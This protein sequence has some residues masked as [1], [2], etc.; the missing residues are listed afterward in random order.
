MTEHRGIQDNTVPEQ[1][2]SKDTGAPRLVSV[3]VWDLPTRFFHWTL[4]V[5]VAACLFT[6]WAGGA[7]RALHLAAGGVVAA[8]VVFRLVWGL[9]GSEDSRF[10]AFPLSA[11][12]MRAH[13][14]DLRH[15]PAAPHR[16]HNPAGA[17]MVVTLLTLLA[18]IVLSGAVA[19]GGVDKQGPFAL[20]SQATGQSGHAVHALLAWTL[21]ALVVL[22]VA[23]VALG[24]RLERVNLVA[25]MI[26]GRKTLPARRRPTVTA[27]PAAA[28]LSFGA[29]VAAGGVVWLALP[30]V[31]PP[32]PLAAVLRDECGGCH[33]PY[34]P[35]VLTATGWRQM[36]AGLADHFGED[37]ALSPDT[38]RTVE[39]ALTQGGTAETSDR[40]VAHWMRSPDPAAP[41]A[42][43]RSAG[44]QARHRA[45]PE[46]VFT[47]RA[48]SGRGHCSA[49][50]ADAQDGLFAPQAIHLPKESPR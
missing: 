28:A 48:V 13:L 4:L 37:A 8:L 44:W 19:W 6:G 43:T 38:A 15:P 46:T 33:E 10:T 45:L 42:V 5:S 50:H 29:I 39:A 17:A 27:R 32:P 24:S 36:I 3:M 41:F 14:R 9:F 7:W 49:C 26:H 31:P 18:A 34:H 22:H 23:G 47:G 12:Q 11:R 25:T 21:P 16:G 40:E 35:I 20:L 1:I 2:R 30:A